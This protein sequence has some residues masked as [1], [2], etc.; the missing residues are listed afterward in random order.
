MLQG[1]A[2]L[3]LLWS[4]SWLVHRVFVFEM[5]N[6]F[7]LQMAEEGA[8]GIAPTAIG[9]GVG[10]SYPGYPGAINGDGVDCACSARR[11]E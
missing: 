4:K 5:T 6:S 7:S 8:N 3:T 9:F 2:I 11:V 1:Q 10:A